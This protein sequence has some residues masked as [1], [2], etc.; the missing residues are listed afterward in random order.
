MGRDRPPSKHKNTRVKY[1]MTYIR[2][3]IYVT[4]FGKIGLNAANKIFSSV[5]PVKALWVDF[6]QKKKNI[7]IYIYILYI[8]DS[9]WEKGALHSNQ[10]K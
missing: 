2:P 9:L 7:Y 6:F 4:G 8:C 3:N 1:K 10:K 5:S